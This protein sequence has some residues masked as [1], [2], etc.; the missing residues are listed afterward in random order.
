MDRQQYD[1]VTNQPWATRDVIPCPSCGST[2]FAETN[3]T[4][5]TMGGWYGNVRF[6][7]ATNPRRVVATRVRCGACGY[8][9]PITDTPSTGETHA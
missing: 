5:V 4:P 8:E 9:E 2:T 6:G 7:W 3:G 1:T